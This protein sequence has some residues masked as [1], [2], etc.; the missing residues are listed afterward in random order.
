M[1]ARLTLPLWPALSCSSGVN[2]FPP[3]L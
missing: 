1:C 3:N 2:L